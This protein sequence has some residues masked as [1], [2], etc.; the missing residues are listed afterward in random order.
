[1]LA[2]Y[3][4][5][6]EVVIDPSVTVPKWSLSALGRERMMAAAGERWVRAVPRIVSSDETKAV[7]T[8]AII[9]EASGARVDVL[10]DLGENDRAATGFLP[11]PEFDA[12]ADAFFTNPETSIR[13]WERAVDAQARIVGA[14]SAVLAAHD[15]SHPIAFSGHGGVGTLLYCA[16]AGLPIDRRHDQKRGGCV[17]AIDLATRRPL[18]GWTPLEQVAMKLRS[19]GIEIGS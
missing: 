11:P 12:T 2:Y 9:A 5:H 14:V 17:I 1:M 13:G 16:L 10:P 4:S 18:F 3:I 8:A 7:E 6:P 19:L 15:P